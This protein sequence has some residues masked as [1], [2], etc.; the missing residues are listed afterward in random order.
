VTPSIPFLSIVLTGRNDDY[1][2]DFRSRF[3]NTLRFNHREMVARGI[4]HEFVFVEWAPAPGRPLLVDLLIEAVPTLDARTLTGY[5]VDN[6][7]H[8]A[9]SLNPRLEFLE[10]LAKNVGIRRACGTFI[11]TTNCD[12]FLS[13]PILQRLQDRDL[14]PRTIYRAPRY[15]LKQSVDHSSLGWEVLE[16]ANNV[17]MPLPYLKPP[18]MGG[19]TGD[20]VLLDRA[21]FGSLRGFNEVYRVARIGIDQNFLVKALSA[22]IRIVD[23]GAPVYHV[24][25]EGSYR[26]SGKLYAGR[27][28]SA[29]YG[30]VCWHSQGVVYDNPFEWGLQNAP[31]RR[32]NE[33]SSV[34]E[35][36][37]NAVPP[38]VDLRRIVLPVARTGFP[39]PG[40]YVER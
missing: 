35:F 24:N 1:G 36:S 10:F 23:I 25:H 33:H 11:L 17:E 5:I 28:A 30:N 34:L 16:D 2:N 14:E 8:Q 18:L 9:L 38:L 22:G 32:R 3:F 31:T 27:E 20:F 26:L 39:S 15:D 29:P 13:R 21:T 6:R 37:W 4:P 19:G 7:Y 40:W 12:V